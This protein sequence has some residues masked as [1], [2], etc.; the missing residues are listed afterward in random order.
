MGRVIRWLIIALSVIVPWVVRFILFV[1]R[2]IITSIC[3]F[4]IGVPKAV[5]RITHS[6]MQRAWNARIPT[7]YD[8]LLHWIYRIIAYVMIFSGWIGLA[9]LTVFLLNWLV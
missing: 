1:G 7:E 2:M 6:W 5:E 4:W 9:Y 3:S 8:D